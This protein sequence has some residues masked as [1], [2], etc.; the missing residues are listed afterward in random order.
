MPI[1]AARAGILGS[2]IAIP[3]S[4]ITRDADNNSASTSEYEGEVLN[5]NSA[6]TRVDAEISANTSGLTELGIY[7]TDG[8]E[9]AVDTTVSTAGDVA[10]F[11]GLSLTSGTDYY[12]LGY[13]GGAS[14]TFGFGPDNHP[15]TAADGDLV[16]AG[17]GSSPSNFTA[18]GTENARVINNVAL[19]R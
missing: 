7:E 2:G 1:G 5:P 14:W 15:Y 6:L 18:G 13:A 11:D 16:G 9:L 3:D 19:F 12:I 8:T 17:G 4:T 10:V